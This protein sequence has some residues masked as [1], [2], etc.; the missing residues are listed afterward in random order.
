MP[1]PKVTRMVIFYRRYIITVQSNIFK[2]EPCYNILMSQR[3]ILIVED[4]DLLR[5]TF[6]SIFT[7]NNFCVVEAK[8]GKAA[9][10]KISVEKVDL[11]LSDI[12]MPVMDGFEFLKKFKET[13]K[14]SI[15][16]IFMT[17]NSDYSKD[18]LI[19]AGAL[20]VI[21]KPLQLRSLL[22]LIEIAISNNNAHVI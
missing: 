6:V 11:I 2:A 13:S 12:K 21:A 22:D 7:A 18:E 15:P 3:K 1:H 8:N 10:Q 17:G 16:F 20:D 14:I 9:L 4:D 5:D 19:A